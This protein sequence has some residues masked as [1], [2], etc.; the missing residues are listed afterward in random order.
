M[1]QL[2]GLMI[3]LGRTAHVERTS[4]SARLPHMLVTHRCLLLNTDSP[5]HYVKEGTCASVML[6]PCGSQSLSHVG[7]QSWCRAELKGRQHEMRLWQDH[8]LLH[9]PLHM[10]QAFCHATVACT[11]AHEGS[12]FA[13]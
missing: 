5:T 3:T 10:Q 9:A 1:Q 2:A 7:M 12:K 4:V 6:F 13:M 11:S 8:H